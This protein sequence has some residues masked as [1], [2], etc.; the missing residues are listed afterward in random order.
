MAEKISKDSQIDELK[1]ALESAREQQLASEQAW[2]IAIEEENTEK[3]AQVNKLIERVKGMEVKQ[4][5]LRQD[6]EQKLRSVQE[7]TQEKYQKSVKQMQEEYQMKLVQEV[8]RF[9]LG[10][11]NRERID[12]SFVARE[13]EDKITCQRKALETVKQ[14]LHQ[15]R[16]ETVSPEMAWD[17]YNGVHDQTG[18]SPQQAIEVHEQGGIKAEGKEFPKRAASMPLEEESYSQSYGTFGLSSVGKRYACKNCQKRHEPPLCGCPNCEGP[19]L[20][21]K[22]PFSGI[23]EGET[24][25]KAGHTEP[26]SRCSVCHL[27]HQGTCRCA[28]CGELAHIAADCIVAGMEEWSHVP[29]SKRSRRDH[30]TPEKKK[31]S[32]T[33]VNHMW[34][35]K[36]GV[37]HPQNELCRYPD[38][39]KSL[40][41][42]TCGNQQNDHL[43]GCPV[44]KGTSILQICKKCEGEGHTQ[45]NCTATG[46][47]CYKCGKMGHLAGE[48]TQMG[49]FAL[50]HQIYDPSSK[51]IRPFFQHCKEEGHWIK[52]CK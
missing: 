11:P 31:P 30:I 43:R 6:M 19:H 22:C 40:W 21:S 4:H 26:W 18:E 39:S 24:V 25:P 41:C 42:S 33:V 29:T 34:C 28:K 48:C 36:C 37:S 20:I 12:S 16:G 9:T 1:V 38:V 14:M 50:R 27:C 8:Q 2:K 44:E 47:P 10:N 46:V 32:T 15:G 51:E 23:L 13:V 45:E 35:G 49:R 3:L 5:E 52:D 7:Q 17:Y